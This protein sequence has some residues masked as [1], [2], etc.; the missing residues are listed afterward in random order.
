MLST[1]NFKEME[2]GEMNTRTG[3][4]N[5]SLI[6]AVVICAFLIPILAQ[7][8][9]PAAVPMKPP[10]L[11]VPAQEE[12][13]VYRLQI[14]VN[15][16]DASKV[17]NSRSYQMVLEDSGNGTIKVTREMPITSGPSTS[18]RSVGLSLS[19]HIIERKDYL[20]VSVRFSLNDVIGGD[21]ATPSSTVTAYPVFR[22]YDSDVSA[23]VKPGV[24]TLI[25]TMDSL[26]SKSRYELEVTATKIR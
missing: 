6:V 22:A 17:I 2:K 23:A 15:E 4:Q 26:T 25:A 8:K 3:S 16:T 18:Y 7:E 11:P 10:P 19:C 12:R 21:P 24:P 9:L 5:R 20:N 13:S 14:N 1:L